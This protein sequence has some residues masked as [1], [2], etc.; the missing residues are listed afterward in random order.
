[1]NDTTNKDKREDKN[2]GKINIP[3]A[4]RLVQISN[5][6]SCLDARFCHRDT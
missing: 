3:T 6:W 4:K 5:K 2:K 1:M